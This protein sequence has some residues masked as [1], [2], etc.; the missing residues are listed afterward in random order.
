ME[1]AGGGRVSATGGDHSHRTCPSARRLSRQ[2]H[3]PTRPIRRRRVAAPLHPDRYRLGRRDDV[4]RVRERLDHR[5]V[6]RPEMRRFRST[7]E[8]AARDP[9]ALPAL[10]QLTSRLSREWM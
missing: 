9:A 10:Q 3:G 8:A 6:R 1:R 7:L 5:I 4:C 2:R